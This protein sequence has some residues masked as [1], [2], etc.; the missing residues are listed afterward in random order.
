M[1]DSCDPL[2]Y[3][4]PGSSEPSPYQMPNP[5]ESACRPPVAPAGRSACLWLSL[6]FTW[7]Q[8]PRLPTALHWERDFLLFDL[9]S[10]AASSCL[11][12]RA[13]SSLVL[14]ASCLTKSSKT[15]SLVI[16]SRI[17]LGFAIKHTN[18]HF[19]N[20]PFEIWG[21]S[22]TFALLP[23]H[24]LHSKIIPSPFIQILMLWKISGTIHNV[25]L[26]P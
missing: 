16:Y 15:T 13:S 19:W 6:W 9:P 21:I 20:V 2:D 24:C 8:P 23:G 5:A 7:A 18:G 22:L 12:N 17:D 11:Q 1:S 10:G 26:G 25:S 3:S 4:P 14:R